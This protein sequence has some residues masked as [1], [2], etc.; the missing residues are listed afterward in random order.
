MSGGS[1]QTDGARDR[2]LPAAPAPRRRRTARGV[3]LL[4]VLGV[5]VLASV[6]G[7]SYVATAS[8]RLEVSRNNL[9]ACRAR[10]LAESGTQHGIYLLRAHPELLAGRT[11]LDTALGPYFADGS[12]HWYK[13]YAVPD[14]DNPLIQTAYGYGGMSEARQRAGCRIRLYSKYVN[15]VRSYGVTA[16]WRLGD[17]SGKARDE[18]D[19]NDGKYKDGVNR[20]MPGA[21]VGDADASAGFD[22]QRARVELKDKLDA[23]SPSSMT[24]AA[25]IKPDDFAVTDTRIIAKANGTRLQDTWWSLGVTSVQGNPVLS[26]QLK[27]NGNTIELIGRTQVLQAGQWAFAAMTFD[28]RRLRLY[29]DGQSVGS[30]LAIGG[31]SR[32]DHVKVWIGDNPPD[33]GSRPF[34][35]Q[36]DEVAMFHRVLGA[37]EIQALHKGRAASVDVLSW[38]E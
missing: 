7:M 29:K 3:A 13:V 34:H 38:E 26:C 14:G 35:G 25:W 24:I 28:G 27:V 17:K 19:A 33:K 2:D 36:I 37:T 10:Y 20:G 21:I 5:V 6:V 12:D 32:D 16:Y 18:M 31:I 23:P 9:M 30:A 15:Q 22:G 11:S 4:L 1:R 8:I